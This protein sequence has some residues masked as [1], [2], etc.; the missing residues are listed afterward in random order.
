VID[1]TKAAYRGFRRTKFWKERVKGGVV[2]FEITNTGKGLHPHMHILCDCRWLAMETPE[3]KRGMSK[4]TIVSLCK[5]A[6]NEL[7]EVWGAY[8]QGSRAS[9]FVERAW[10]KALVETLKYA[11]KPSEL[12]TVKG[13]ASD[14]I[15]EIDSGR[16]MSC[17]GHAH[18]CS[19]DFVG[20]DDA[21]TNEYRCSTCDADHSILPVSAIER[22]LE[23][24]GSLNQK[25]QQHLAARI[26]RM[27]VHAGIYSSAW[28]DG[29]VHWDHEVAGT[30][31]AAYVR[32]TSGRA[33][34]IMQGRKPQV[35]RSN[36]DI[37]W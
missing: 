27:G 36:D 10:G 6:A 22:M 30:S 14:I 28:G 32:N 37:P 11:I 16:M 5:R 7:A 20:L 23:K 8:V 29:V 18:A 2:G 31:E 13:S 25:W 26:E 24:P 9:V 35:S 12:V 15:D 34:G 19:K 17:F 33:K 21:V 4:K 1:R 3:P